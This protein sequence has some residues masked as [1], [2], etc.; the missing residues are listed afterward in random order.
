VVTI[1][2]QHS[3]PYCL[4]HSLAS[5]LFYCDS[6]LFRIASEGLVHLGK[7]IAGLHFDAQIK[8]VREYMET[9]VPLIGRPTLFG[10]RANSHQRKL[11][12]M[13]W[14]DLLLNITPFPTVVIPKLP[15]GQATHAFCVVDDLIFDSTTPNALRLSRDAVKWLF[16]EVFPEIYQ[17][18]RFNRKVSPPGCSIWERY[19]RKI[20]Y[21]WQHPTKP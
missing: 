18:L 9:H 17:V 11:R 12:Q 5:A 1:Y 8:K 16:R 10:K 6:D 7:T 4:S 21:H 2:Q 19:D 13:T 20:Q 3:N 14:D 15:S